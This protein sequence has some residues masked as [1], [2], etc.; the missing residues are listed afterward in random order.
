MTTFLLV[1]GAW[2]GGWSWKKLTPLLRGAGHEVFTPTLTGL[3]ERAH[4]LSPAIDLHT[5]VQDILGVL[6][7]EDLTNVILVGHSYGGMLITAVAE[8]VPERLA[9]LVYLDAFVPQDGQSLFD[10]LLADQLQSFQEQARTVGDGWR[11][12]PPPLKV[13]GITDEEDVRWMSS[14]V[15]DHPIKTFMEP[16]RLSNPDAAALPRT[17]ISC[18]THPRPALV[19]TAKRLRSDPA[20]R[21]RELVAGHDAMVTEVRQTA[22]LLLEVG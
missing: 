15:G 6:I 16:V 12:P 11:L 8:R 21:Y 13:W 2:H 22:D 1:H 10:F 18:T 19:A 7:C 14:R 5:H 9:H 4:L 20:W 3:G 17:F